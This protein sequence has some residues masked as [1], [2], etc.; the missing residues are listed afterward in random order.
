M[1]LILLLMT[2]VVNSSELLDLLLDRG[3]NAATRRGSS[4]GAVITNVEIDAIQGY[5]VGNGNR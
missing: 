1:L 2:H 3:Q 4:S 5:V